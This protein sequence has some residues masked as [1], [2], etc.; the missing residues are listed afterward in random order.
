MREIDLEPVACPRPRVTRRGVF[1]PPKYREWSKKAE[2]ILRDLNL[3]KEEGALSLRIVFVIKRPQSL[4]RRKDPEG[5]IPHTKRPDLDNYLKAF[6]D[7]AQKAELLGD[8]SELYLI[9][10]SKFYAA[11]TETPKIIF[12]INKSSRDATSGAKQQRR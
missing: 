4:R 8:D 10:A 6:L 9:Q 7:S 3:Q 11:K 2:R 1:Y 12:Q 5:R